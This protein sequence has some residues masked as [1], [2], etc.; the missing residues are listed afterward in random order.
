LEHLRKTHGAGAEKINEIE[1]MST[2]KILNPASN[3]VASIRGIKWGEFIARWVATITTSGGA[4]L[5]G[6]QAA[7]K[8]VPVGWQWVVG[9]AAAVIAGLLT[10]HIFGNL[11]QRVTYNWLA[12][13][14]PNVQKWAEEDTDP[15]F[16]RMRQWGNT[17]Y[18]ILLIV[19]FAFDMVTTVQ[20]TDPVADSAKTTALI[21]IDSLRNAVASGLQADQT[22]YKA[23]AQA[24]EKAIQATAGRVE[25]QDPRLAR[26]KATGN[27]W[28]ASQI[29]RRQSRATA[30]DARA[31][32][33]ADSAYIALS[34]SAPAYID[35]R[36]KEAEALNRAAQ[37]RNQSGRST[38]YWMYLLFSIVPKG[39]AVFLRVQMVVI[40]LAYSRDYN[41]DIT[42]DGIID[43]RDV[44][45]MT[46]ADSGK[47]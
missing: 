35:A 34:T 28:A 37:E 27:G 15:Y 1:I 46:S 14:H 11:L 8:Y 32:A 16:I 26:L 20:I 39:L 41:P 29:S 43:Y 23:D 3:E 10:D 9:I 47:K 38:M 4:Y 30:S 7:A 5:F 31:K 6:L 13:D 25:A 17:G 45:A 18:V 42:G 44:D 21:N 33:A 40:F 12:A 36:V 19:L 24:R 2:V 22:R